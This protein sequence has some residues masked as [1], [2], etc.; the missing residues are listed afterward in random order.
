VGTRR[1]TSAGDPF[2]YAGASEESSALPTK[3]LVNGTTR[4][5]RCT[6]EFIDLLIEDYRIERYALV[7]AFMGM[8]ASPKREAIALCEWAAKTDEPDRALLAWARKHQRG[9]FA[10]PD[11]AEEV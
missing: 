9:A 4:H 3:R 7:N 5:I 1:I 2:H 11:E 8:P 10:R 6:H